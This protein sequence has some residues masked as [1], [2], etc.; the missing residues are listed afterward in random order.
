MHPKDQNKII[1]IETN[2][3]SRDYLRSIIYESNYIAFCFEK[4]STFLDNLSPLNPNLVIIGSLSSEKVFRLI[5]TIKMI[6]YSLP[7]LIISDDDNVKN[8][9]KL[10]G[11][12]DV[13]TLKTY[14]ELSEFKEIISNILKKN[15]NVKRSQ[16]HPFI[17]GNSSSMVKIKKNIPALSR[18]KEIIFIR[19]ESGTGKDL[20]AKYIH[21][22]SDRKDNPFIKSSGLTFSREIIEQD[23]ISNSR[24]SSVSENSQLN[25]LE[26]ADKGTLFIDKIEEIPASFQAKL[27]QLIEMKDITENYGK[28]KKTYDIRMI[29]S[30]RTDLESFVEKGKFR[31]ELY[32]RLNVLR[33]DIP[34]LRERKEDIPL[35]TDFFADK[36]C[37]EFGKSHYELSDEIKNRFCNYLWPGNVKE[38][39]KFVNKIIMLGDEQSIINK[40]NLNNKYKFQD[41]NNYCKNIY[42]LAELADLKNYMNDI[43]KI[44]LK[45]ICREFVARAERKLMKKVLESTNWNRKKAA[46]I[47]NISYK[48]LLNKVKAYN[49]T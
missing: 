16:K 48:S 3:A 18:S 13:M 15:T 34:P 24:V 40:L 21:Y 17:I 31:K 22:R 7:V 37:R 25:S 35:L 32:Y 38:L 19:G 9:T 28:T 46:D 29:V 41:I 1:I 36:F 4:E 44:S 43:N 26:M 5:N 30:A 47:L 42:N 10:N 20:I 49:L 23:L 6:N 2:Q 39:E 27:V 8:F 45:D 12:T 11:F 33:L 14:F